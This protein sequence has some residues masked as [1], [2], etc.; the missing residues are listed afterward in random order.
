VVRETIAALADTGCDELV[1]VPTTLDIT[2]LER[3]VAVMP[4]R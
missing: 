4:G 2:E 3:L 1:L